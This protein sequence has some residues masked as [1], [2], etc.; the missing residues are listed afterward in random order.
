MRAALAF[1]LLIGPAL[2][3]H[4]KSGWPYPWE[5]CSDKDCWMMGDDADSH[6]PEP[7]FD[8]G[9]WV[10]HDGY[11]IADRDARPSPDGRFHV[12]RSGGHRNGGV[13]MPGGRPPCLWVPR[14]A[15]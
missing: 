11:R 10:L 8:A 14:G 9:F 7:R 12:C 4:A 6:E 1:L 3:H 2:A 5:C 15:S 13:I